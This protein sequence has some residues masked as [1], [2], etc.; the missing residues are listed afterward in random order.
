MEGAKDGD[1]CTSGGRPR[2]FQAVFE[3]FNNDGD[4]LNDKG[5]RFFICDSSAHIERLRRAAA[6]PPARPPAQTRRPP[7]RRPDDEIT[8]ITFH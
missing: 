5:G 4:L 8:R 7:R 3:L 2:I 1:R 6:R